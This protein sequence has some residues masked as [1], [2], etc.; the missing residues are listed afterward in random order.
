MARPL[1]DRRAPRWLAAALVCL[2][3]L[4]G[5]VRA[6]APEGGLSKEMGELAKQVA[7][8]VKEKGVASVR[9]GQFS[10][11]RIGD[12]AGLP[13]AAGPG[14]ARA[15]TVEL[16]KLG[17]RVEDGAGL[18]VVGDYFSDQD[19]D[20]ERQA[21][22][23]R[24]R[25]L[26]DQKNEVLRLRGRKLFGLKPIAALLALTVDDLPP[27]EGAQDRKLRQ[28]MT[29]PAAHLKGTRTS[30]GRGS[31]Y[32]VEILVKSGAGYVA[33][34]AEDRDGLAYVPL[35]K[36]EEYA[37]RLVNDSPHDAAVALSIDGLSL[38]A[39]S[40][41]KEYTHVLVP[42]KS[43]GVIKG[44]HRSDEKSD[45]F[46]VVGYADSAAAK[47]LASGATL[48]TVTALFAVAWKEGESPPT[49]ER[50][51]AADLGTGR[52][53]SLDQKYTAQTRHFGRTRATVSVRYS[54]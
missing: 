34:A 10:E 9:V 2:P 42:A 13:T 21:I 40:A 31:P 3:V 17:V 20:E 38:F 46:K 1:R 37:V 22:F 44:W 24:G 5:G 4:V 50:S 25:L 8:Y 53:P 49:D 41:N 33:R 26:D 6:A 32:A 29:R 18:E 51:R 30:A 7:V 28:S 52:G 23:I 36:G 15:L 47:A 48:G 12:L 39:F 45:A 11:R 27:D 43:T 14:L 19:R 16:K 35:K 54:K